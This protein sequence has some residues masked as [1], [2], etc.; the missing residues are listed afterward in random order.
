MCHRLCSACR[1]HSA[2][3]IGSE[4]TLIEWL[5]QDRIVLITG[6]AGSGKST[7]LRHLGGLLLQQDHLP[8]WL[9]PGERVASSEDLITRLH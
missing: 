2:P 5:D 1:T 6:D 7:L 4:E 9:E 8:I 3:A